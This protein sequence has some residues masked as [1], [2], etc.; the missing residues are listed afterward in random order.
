MGGRVSRKSTVES[1]SGEQGTCR[2]DAVTVIEEALLLRA[3]RVVPRDE[4]S[5]LYRDEGFLYFE[6]SKKILTRVYP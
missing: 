6:I 2:I 1:Q 4:L 5:S 3:T